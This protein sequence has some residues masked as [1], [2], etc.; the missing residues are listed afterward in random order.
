MKFGEL[1]AQFPFLTLVHSLRLKGL[2][3]GAQCELRP[4]VVPTRR[5]LGV[6]NILTFGARRIDVF[7]ISQINAA[8]VCMVIGC[9]IVDEGKV[10]ALLVEWG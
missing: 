3:L 6:S 8:N 2:S 1:L 10:A 4:C 9:Y 5:S 7:F